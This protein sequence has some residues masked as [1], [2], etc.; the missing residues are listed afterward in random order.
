MPPQNLRLFAVATFFIALAPGPNMLLVMSSSVKCGVRR[1]TAT[2]AGCLTAVVSMMALSAAGVGALLETA[3]L[4]FQALQFLGAAYLAY[5]GARMWRSSGESS[6]ENPA[7]VAVK[8]AALYRQGFLVAASNPKAL[9]FAAAF[10]PQFIDPSH[11]RLPQ[12]VRLVGI[13]AAIET[14]CYFTYAFGGKQLAERLKKPA[15]R[16]GFD[17]VTGVAFVLFAAALLVEHRR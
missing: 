10:L 16:R 5:L 12:F 1:S 8:S 14:S 4:V 2:M 9:L 7:S 3:P 13:F 11:A 17:R 6:P 15:V